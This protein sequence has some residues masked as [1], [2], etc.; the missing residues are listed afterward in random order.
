MTRAW[1]RP[2]WAGVALL[3]AGSPVGAVVQGTANTASSSTPV[4]AGAGFG[5]LLLARPG[6]PAGRSAWRPGASAVVVVAAAVV[7]ALGVGAAAGGVGTAGR[8]PSTGGTGAGR[9]G[10]IGLSPFTSLRGELRQSVP[11]ELFRVTGLPRP[12]SPSGSPPGAPRT[13]G[14]G[15]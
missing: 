12:G 10:E 7:V 1:P 3:L 15:R 5:L 4:A 11:A 14:P 13:A 9:V 6:P 8:F 2:V